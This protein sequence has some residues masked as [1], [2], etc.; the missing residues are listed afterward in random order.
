[1]RRADT[2]KPAVSK[3]WEP[4]WLCSPSSRSES[5]P[6]ED[7]TRR[8]EGVPTRQGEAELL[9]L[10]GR[11]DELV[12]VGLHA[13]RDPDEHRRHDSE[14]ARDGGDTLDLVEGVDDDA[15]HALVERR[16]DLGDALVVAVQADPLPRHAGPQC[17][18]ELTAG[19]DVEVQ[20]LV[21]D[22][23]GHLGAEERLAGIEDVG[24][25][26]ETV[27]H[28]GIRLLEIPCARTEVI[29]VDDVCR[30]AE[31]SCQLG[32]AHSADGQHPVATAADRRR[33]QRGYESIDVDRGPQPGGAAIALRV[34]RSGFVCVH[35]YI[36]SGAAA[37]SRASP[38]RKT[39]R[40]VSASA[41]PRAVHALDRGAHDGR[42]HRVV[43]RVGE[44]SEVDEGTRARGLVTGV[45]VEA[46]RQ[47]GHR[48]E[49]VT[50]RHVGEQ[51]EPV[52]RPLLH[53]GRLRVAQ[54]PAQPRV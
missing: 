47:V 38:L 2:S 46:L 50:L 17:D 44:V 1:M 48:D 28:L 26:R 30:G 31:L 6:L 49:Q 42:P 5:G 15:A 51:L 39:T 45:R 3:I 10:V 18:G 11:R 29:L 24:P 32:D 40:T 22:P 14:L 35:P 12:G 19:A 21:V 27:E 43:P 23:P 25:T 36:L 37:P 8:L 4:M 41:D 13:D 7:A 9:V 20:P 54:Q 34:Q 52:A 53:P 33:P 16:A